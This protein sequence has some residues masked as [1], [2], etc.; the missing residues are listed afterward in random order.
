M[1]R[2][3]NGQLEVVSVRFTKRIRD[4]IKQVAE[5]RGSDESTVIRQAVHQELARLSFLTN[6]EKKALGLSVL[7][8]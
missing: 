7:T 3:D 8:E 6:N 2:D 5:A 1:A 4:I